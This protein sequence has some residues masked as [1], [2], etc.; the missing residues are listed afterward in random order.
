[1]PKSEQE[2]DYSKLGFFKISFTLRQVL[3]CDDGYTKDQPEPLPNNFANYVNWFL[4]KK[5]P[6]PL[7]YY[8]IFFERN[9]VSG[10]VKNFSNKFGQAQILGF[11]LILPFIR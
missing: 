6:V 7:V 8:R 3:P 10:I 11:P 4:L 2:A 9:T 5:L 1:V